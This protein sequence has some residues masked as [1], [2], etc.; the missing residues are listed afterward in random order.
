MNRYLGIDMGGTGTR[1]VLT[2]ARGTELGRGRAPGATGHLFNPE[3]RA[4]FSAVIAEIAQQSGGPVDGLYAGVT[5]L[6]GKAVE[7]AREILSKALDCPRDTIWASD[8]MSLAYRAIFAPGEGHLVSAGTG[9]VGLHIGQDGEPI[10]VGGRGILI[11]DGGSGAWIALRSLDAVFREIDLKGP[12]AET[13]PLAEHLFAAIGGSDWD[14][15]RAYIYG[16]D[17]GQ[18]G[19][20]AQAVA[21]AARAGDKTALGLLDAAGREL[22]RLAQ[23]L[24]ARGGH[25]PVAFIGGVLALDPGI[26]ERLR[27]E[28]NDIELV[29]PKVDAALSGAC[30]AAEHY[31]AR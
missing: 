29:F 9:S 28:L 8:D 14:S 30:L 18:I 7:E 4:R 17:R 16:G 21:Q 2:D 11:D 5:G 24:V 25:K 26:T 1:W 27:A 23:A 3:A 20:L 10:R 31:G 15:V 19:A 6:G 13:T 22:A 12:E